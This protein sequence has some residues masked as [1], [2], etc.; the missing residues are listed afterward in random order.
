VDL[1]IMISGTITDASGRTLSGQ[2]VEAFWNSIRHSR[3][4]VVGL[5]CALGAKQLRP[6][7]EDFSRIADVAVCA[8]PNAGLPNAF[9]EYDEQACDT[10]ALVREFAEAGTG[11][12]RRRLL[13]HHRRSHRAYPRG[14]RQSSDPRAAA[15][16]LRAAACRDSSRSTSDPTA[17]SSTSASAPTSPVR[18]SFAA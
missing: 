13:R 6:Y 8:Y 14:G 9:G 18:R 4:T 12:H 1:P 11:Q 16:R 2:T 5:N 15:P 3:P 17:C 7:V 10:A